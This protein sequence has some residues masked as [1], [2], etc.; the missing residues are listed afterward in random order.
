MNELKLRGVKVENEEQINS[1]VNNNENIDI[2][3]N[4]G[5]VHIV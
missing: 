1:L 4:D 3:I 2:K 5:I